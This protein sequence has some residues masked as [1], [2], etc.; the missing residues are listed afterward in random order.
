ML[1]KTARF[2]Y[3][4]RTGR[5]G[6]SSVYVNKKNITEVFSVK[7][8]KTVKKI[9]ALSTGAVM[10]GA[11]VLS[12]GATDLSEYP[13]PWVQNGRFNG[14]IVV[15][16][17]PGTS[18]ADVLGAIDIATTLQYATRVP[19]NVQTGGSGTT[20]RLS[21]V[22]GEAWQVEDLEVSER[23]AGLM[24]ESISDVTSEIGMAELPTLLADGTLQASEDDYDYSQTFSFNSSQAEGDGTLKSR[25]VVFAESNNPVNDDMTDLFFYIKRGDQIA[26][27]VLDFEGSADSDLTNSD[28]DVG[29]G[30][31]LYDIEG[32]TIEL[33][34][35]E[36]DIIEAEAIQNAAEDNAGVKL[37]LMGGATYASLS[38]G[39]TG[40][41]TV[42][43][44]DYIVTLALLT[45]DR[46][47]FVVNGDST[48][49]SLRVGDTYKLG[50]GSLI[51]VKDVVLQEFDGGLRFAEFYIGANKVELEDEDITDGVYGSS[52]Y[53]GNTVLDSADVKITGKIDVNSVELETIEINI[54]ADDNVFLPADSTIMLSDQLEEPEVLMEAWDIQFAGMESANTEQISIARSSENQYNLEFVDGDG[55]DVNVPLLYA[56]GDSNLRFGNEDNELLVLHE[57]QSIKIDDYFVVSDSTT[58]EH[59]RETYVVQ[60]EKA[61]RDKIQFKVVGGERYTQDYDL[62]EIGNVDSGTVVTTLEV[63]GQ[64]YKVVTAARFVITDD[65]TEDE[66]FDIKVDLNGDG[67]IARSFGD[68]INITTNAGARITIAG[69]IAG[70]Y[71]LAGSN[72]NV[73][74]TIDEGEGY[75][76]D[77][78]NP[79][80]VGL[81]ITAEADEVDAS[82]SGGHTFIDAGSDDKVAYTTLGARVVYDGSEDAPTLTM[83]FPVTQRLAQVFIVTPEVQISSTDDGGTSTE[84]GAGTFYKTNAISVGTAKLASEVNDIRAQNA[85]VVGGPCANEAAKVL[86]GNPQ[87]CGKD[88]TPNTALIRLFD[89]QTETLQCS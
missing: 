20:S 35:K 37:T 31:I 33:L 55:N 87:P 88:F 56:P 38:L 40:E 59:E 64:D 62:V 19:I 9:L 34:G 83:D 47:K 48:R 63:G 45:E 57:S 79:S 29:E 32:R 30:D 41:Y 80:P 84:S 1:V 23:G 74:V 3:Y 54:K 22:G 67:D 81:E 5:S 61:R 2:K 44:N 70:H 8:M 14:I 52:L 11:T 26:E 49:R 68:A 77:N 71:A 16:D 43:D 50:D 4:Q 73:T 10:V 6:A 12:A 7:L 58:S 89:I 21:I 51:G 76:I 42:A 60:Y 46:A 18:P 39:E 85:I 53:V 65:G 17:N 82:Q 86:M 25:T 75:D 27:Y 36:W 72:A 13:A 69:G 15:G 66:A 24:T 28:G 78:K